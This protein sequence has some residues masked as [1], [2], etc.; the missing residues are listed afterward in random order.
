M[1]GPLQRFVR[2][3]LVELHSLIPQSIANFFAANIINYRLTCVREQ[4]WQLARGARQ[5]QYGLWSEI[6]DPVVRKLRRAGP[7]ASLNIVIPMDVCLIR[8]IAIPAAARRQARDIAML[9]LVH[10]TPFNL[11]NAFVGHQLF[12]APDAS[13]H[14]K[15][16]V[17]K[18]Q[19]LDDVEASDIPIQ[20]VMVAGEQGDIRLFAQQPDHRS[21]L[22]RF[23]SA[24]VVVTLAIAVISS[25]AFTVVVLNGQAQAIATIAKQTVSTRRQALRIERD[26]SAAAHRLVVARSVVDHRLATVT[27]LDMWAEA[28][29]TLPDTA[30]IQQFQLRGRMLHLA[31]VAVSPE[32]V[33]KRLDQSVLFEKVRFASALVPAGRTKRVAFQLQLGIRPGGGAKH[34]E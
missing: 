4:R 15:Q 30:W 1:I 9:D 5:L 10:G 25:A 18:R 31:G 19:L 34:A 20:H 29:R 32:R 27:A 22:D 24:A 7:L 13:W 16:I 12:Q 33:L 17:A 14:I 21:G 8:E 28:T 6:R 23:S 26:Q 3:W 11:S 2:W